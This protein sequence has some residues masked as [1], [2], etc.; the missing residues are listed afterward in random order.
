MEDLHPRALR[1]LTSQSHVEAGE[2]Q[3][4]LTVQVFGLMQ[5]LGFGVSFW[6]DGLRFCIVVQFRVDE[7]QSRDAAVSDIETT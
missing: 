6:L 3:L 2:T 7:F 5:G 4:E 1:V